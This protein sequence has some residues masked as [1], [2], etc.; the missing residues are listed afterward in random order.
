MFL[1]LINK[2]VLL[3]FT[4]LVLLAGC[5]SN[6]GGFEC[7]GDSCTKGENLSLSFQQFSAE[8]SNIEI[9]EDVSLTTV[10]ILSDLDGLL[11]DDFNIEFQTSDNTIIHPDDI[12]VSGSLDLLSITITPMADQYGSLSITATLI[13]QNNDQSFSKTIDVEVLPVNDLPVVTVNSSLSLING[14]SADKKTVSISITDIDSSYSAGDI[15]F[16]VAANNLTVNNLRTSAQAD[17]FTF[18]VESKNFA[19]GSFPLEVLVTDPNAETVQTA[20]SS[21]ITVTVSNAD[22]DTDGIADYTDNCRL[23]PNNNQQNNDADAKGDACDADDDNDGVLDVD[24]DFPFDSGEDNDSDLDGVG[25]NSDNCVNE[26]NIDQSDL[27]GDGIGDACD[28]IRD[29]SVVFSASIDSGQLNA[30]VNCPSCATAPYIY[31]NWTIDSQVVSTTNSFN[32]QGSHLNKEITLT[33]SL[34]RTFI[35][36]VSKLYKFDYVS[37]VYYASADS[38]LVAKTSMGRVITSPSYG[39]QTNEIIGLGA[40]KLL[41]NGPSLSAFSFITD[42]GDVYRFG[43]PN[44]GG[45]IFLASA[46]GYDK[47]FSALW[48][49]FGFKDDGSYTSWGSNQSAPGAIPGGGHSTPYVVGLPDIT[50][51]ISVISNTRAGGAILPNGKVKTWGYVTY[52]SRPSDNGV[53]G[54]ELQS[55]VEKII[56]SAENWTTNYYQDK[57]GFSIIKTGGEVIAWGGRCAEPPVPYTQECPDN[58]NLFNPRLYDNY[59]GELDSGVVDIVSTAQTFL[60]LK[61]SGELILWGRCGSGNYILPALYRALTHVSTPVTEIRSSAVG[62]LA[63]HSDSHFSA[64]GCNGSSVTE[65]VF[66]SPISSLMAYYTG[67]VFVESDGSMSSTSSTSVESFDSTIR[68]ISSS[69]GFD[70]A[71][72]NDNSVV[73]T[74]GAVIADLIDIYMAFPSSSYFIMALSNDGDLEISGSSSYVDPIT[75]FLNLFQAAIVEITP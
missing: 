1:R 32:F 30:T 55:G 45:S 3:P 40:T 5:E 21:I 27:D 51:A 54:S 72:L 69:R 8:L 56:A 24:D 41:V 70:L 53:S 33:I 25:D 61:D 62:Y 44:L 49:F 36:S 64:I 29:L 67:W 71:V 57:G 28:D 46:S 26:A 10:K 18:G 17:T 60:A 23:I 16:N 11:P 35:N 75:P 73:L 20:V 47:L 52:G 19:T 65:Y 74:S 63:I 9:E 37:D 7:V 59:N 15:G 4:A 22:S 58:L 39:E 14:V 6:S 38:M 34:N 31:Y 48:H 50:S 43:N 42:Q 13:N 12:V 66:D 68:S 2:Y